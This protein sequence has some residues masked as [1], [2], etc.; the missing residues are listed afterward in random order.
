MDKIT[1]VNL[2]NQVKEIKLS[3][4]PVVLIATLPYSWISD[5]IE[6]IENKFN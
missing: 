6:A 1:Y 4:V 3:L 2:V 5:K